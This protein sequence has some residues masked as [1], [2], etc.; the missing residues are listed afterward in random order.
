MKRLVVLLAACHKTAPEPPIAEAI[1]G[2]WEVWCATDKETTST[3]RGKDDHALVKTFTADGKVA[4]SG[5]AG[6]PPM[7]GAWRLTGDQLDIIYSGGGLSLQE[8]YRARTEDGRLVLWKADSHFGSV[9]GRKGEAFVAADSPRTTGDTTHGSISGVAY[10]LALPADYRLARDDNKRQRWEP[11]SGEGLRVDLVL[12]PRPRTEVDGKWV[13]PPCEAP[14]SG[15]QS[16][17]QRIDGVDRTTSAGISLCLGEQSLSCDASHTRGY[18]E[19]T[20]KS[21][22]IALCRTLATGT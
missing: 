17:G 21:A 16:S 7:I 11:A 4:L 6:G 8:H 13:T 2:A 15:I 19:D 12:G 22:A 14:S 20:E 1:L 9:L 10:T 18:L 5:G 3:C